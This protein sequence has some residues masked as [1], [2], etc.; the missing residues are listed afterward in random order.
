MSTPHRDKL[1]ILH[2]EDRVTPAA[3]V[4]AGA[5]TADPSTYVPG[6]VLFSIADGADRNQTLMALATSPLAS[7][8]KE[9]GFGVFQLTL[10]PGVTVRQALEGLNGNGWLANVEPNFRRQWLFTPNDPANA[11]GTQW[12]HNN[13]GQNGGLADADIDAFEAW[14]LGRGT[15][16]HIVAVLDSGTA[17]THPDMAAN[18]WVNPGEIAGNGIDDDGNGLIDDI[19]GYDFADNDPDPTEDPGV[20]HGSHVSGTVGAVGNNGIGGSGVA[21]TTRVMAMRIGGAAGP[22]TAAGIAAMAYAAQNGASIINGSYGGAGFSFFEFLAV[23]QLTA[24]GV[25]A[26][27]AAGNGGIDGIGDDNDTAPHY[28]SNFATINSRVI[29]VAATNRRDEIAGFSNFG[30]NSVTL[31]APGVDIFSTVTGNTYDLFSG[32]SMASPMVAGALAVAWD[33]FPSLTVNEVVELLKVSVD[34]IPALDGITVTG[35]RLN[36]HKMLLNATFR[37]YAVGADAGGEPLVRVFAPDGSQR[38]AFY[39]YDTRF[40]G[41]VRIAMADVNGDRVP[42]IITVPGAGGGPNVRVFDGRDLNLLYSFQAYPETFTAGLYVAAGDLD[43]DGMAE[44][45]TGAGEGGAANV[46]VFRLEGNGVISLASSFYAYTSDFSGGVR[47]AVGDYD[48]DGVKDIVTSPGFGGGPHVKV[49]D[50][51]AASTG[52]A[53]ILTQFMAGDP[54]ANVGVYVALGNITSDGIAD[55]IVG[56][57]SIDRE[58]RVYDGRTLAFQSGFT[59]FQ[60]GQSAP[61]ATGTGAPGEGAAVGGLLGNV[62]LPN[63]FPV[64]S[65]VET[66]PAATGPTAGLRVAVLD[67]DQDGVDD[68]IASG[69]AGDRS[70]VRVRS[71]RTMT[72]LG[73][74]RPVFGSGFLGGVFVA[75]SR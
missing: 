12:A 67:I 44:L 23:N 34:P 60:P 73:N 15:G 50:G 32:T 47:V 63:Q 13:T 25:I 18:L 68:I 72:T 21:L 57:G 53:V 36:L 17:L 56:S 41:G 8:A 24:A 14:S 49:F 71:G 43:G 9:L 38:T 35:G 28:P 61:R 7:T 42:D 75:A 65:T 4:T 40:R 39:A 20:I 5:L 59:V 46:R 58:V 66:T 69:G 19:H 10:R 62:G 22:S 29:A 6:E 52:E 70:W 74:D 30:R 11:D 16:Q 31:G 45:I 1:S 37:G 55:F 51:A 27:F 26:V 48:G 3:V 54:R 2:L 64:Q 33:A